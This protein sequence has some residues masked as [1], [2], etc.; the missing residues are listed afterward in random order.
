MTTEHNEFCGV[1]AVS[2]A[3]VEA[4]WRIV[5]SLLPG[6]LSCFFPQMYAV[7]YECY[8]EADCADCVDFEV[9]GHALA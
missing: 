7:H 2:D 9:S 8:Y 6:S 3:V 1:L 4:G 5:S